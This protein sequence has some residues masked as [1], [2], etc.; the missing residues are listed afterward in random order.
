MKHQSSLVFML[1]L[2]G[3]KGHGFKNQIRLASLISLTYENWILIKSSEN[4]KKR[5]GDVS[6]RILKW[7]RRIACV[8]LRMEEDYLYID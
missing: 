1:C 7:Y 4:C 6:L 8:E 3:L 2:V 5:K